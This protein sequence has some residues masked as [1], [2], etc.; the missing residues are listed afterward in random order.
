MTCIALTII[1]CFYFA[2]CAIY[3][4]KKVVR[5]KSWGIAK[6]VSIITVVA[7]IIA[8]AIFVILFSFVLQGKLM[9]RISHSIIVFSMWICA[10]QFYKYLISYFKDKRSVALSIIGMISSVGIAIFLTP[11][12]RFCSTIYFHFQEVTLPLSIGIIVFIYVII[13]C[14]DQTIRKS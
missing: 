8:L 12:D 3:E 13:F 2:I 9:E 7:P 4:K 11:L 6:I 1:I 10:L 14:T 5:K